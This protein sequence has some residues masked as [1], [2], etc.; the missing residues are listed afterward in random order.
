ME[1][2]QKFKV[3]RLLYLTIRSAILDW[4]GGCSVGKLVDQPVVSRKSV[5]GFG[6]KVSDRRGYAILIAKEWKLL[7]SNRHGARQK[8]L[9][10]RTKIGP[11]GGHL[12]QSRESGKE[13]LFGTPFGKHAI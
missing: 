12:S 8:S 3:D 1:T 9:R 10:V 11:F 6:F 2:F 7:L 4:V 5:V 13:V